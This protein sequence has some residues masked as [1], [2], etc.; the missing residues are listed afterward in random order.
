MYK[1]KID[2]ASFF[3]WLIENYPNSLRI[4][5]ENPDHQYNFN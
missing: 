5:R 4:I 3:T 2:V 1:D